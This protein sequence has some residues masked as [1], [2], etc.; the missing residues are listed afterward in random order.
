M[1]TSHRYWLFQVPGLALTCGVAAVASIW[2]GLPIW[3]CGVILVLWIV[4]DALLYPL[5]KNS[6]ET[7]VPTGSERLIGSTGVVTQRLN[8]EGYIKVGAELWQ[9]RSSAVIDTGESVTVERSEAMILI[10]EPQNLE[11]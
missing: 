4:K 3:A 5:L 9:A 2:F 6:Y 7:N 10:V 1:K 11:Q 8:P